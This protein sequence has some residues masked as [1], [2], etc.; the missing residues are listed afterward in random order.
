MFAVLMNQQSDSKVLAQ[1]QV[2]MGAN[3]EVTIRKAAPTQIATGPLRV[4]SIEI[5]E[6]SAN[7]AI[8]RIQVNQPV[9]DY[10]TFT[11]SDPPRIVIDIT[12]AHLEEPKLREQPG[13]GP[14]KQIRSSQYRRKPEPVVR[15]VI[16]LVAALPYQVAGLPDTFRLLIGEAVAKIDQVKPLAPPPA[17]AEKSKPG[18]EEPLRAAVQEQPFLRRAG[19]WGAGQYETLDRDVTTFEDGYDSDIWRVTIGADYM[20][21]NHVI[22][23]LAFDYYNHDGDFDSGGG[24]TAD[25]YGIIGYAVFLPVDDLFIQVSGGWATI[26]Y[27]R[28]RIAAFA[29][30]RS[31]TG[32]TVTV[33]PPS[34]VRGDYDAGQ[35]RIAALTAYDYSIGNVTL[36]PRAGIDYRYIDFDT[37][38]ET[39][40][41]GLELTIHDDDQKWLQSRLGLQALVAFATNFGVVVPQASLDWMHEF[42]NDQR[43]VEVSF[44]G[45][46]R[47]KRFSY[48]TESPDRNWFEFNA[49]VTFAFVPYGVQ[50]FGNYRTWLGQKNYDSHAGTIGVRFS[51]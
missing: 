39:G 45:D 38:S 18:N 19:L 12:G 33:V 7:S 6:A 26:D 23:G 24:F 16:D 15:V 44:V 9:V 48:E 43:N 37:Y 46:T 30:T 5:K 1:E 50:A 28:R 22:A 8:I 14:I 36:S 34:S 31:T 35:F 27:D 20:F 25:S 41:T 17:T 32:E 42:E 49:G 10:N 29:D 40:D 2:I 13:K 4:T 21:T 51:F 3:S 11:L 47:Q